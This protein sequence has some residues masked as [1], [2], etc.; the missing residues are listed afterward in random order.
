MNWTRIGAVFGFLGVA[1]GAFGAH[2]LEAHLVELG[3]VETWETAVLYNLVHAVAV[4]LPAAGAGKRFPAA[5]FF[6][7]G[8]TIFSG[9]LY[10]L[11]LT[12]M[13]WLGAITPIG[14]VFLLAGWLRLVL[15]PP[16]P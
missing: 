4:L 11:C 3:R 16:G 9:S 15:A 6:A 2:A 12:G 8:T 14:G 13:T 10:I 5:L 1:L 7:I